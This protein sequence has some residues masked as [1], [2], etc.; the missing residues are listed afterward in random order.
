MLKHITVLDNTTSEQKL[1]NKS[2]STENM[3]KSLNAT[4][5]SDCLCLL[6]E[7]GAEGK[8]GWLN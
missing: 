2:C 3:L 8:Q 1:F 7:L 4:F 5:P 6:A